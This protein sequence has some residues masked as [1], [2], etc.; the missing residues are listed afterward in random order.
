MPSRSRKTHSNGMSDGA[1]TVCDLPLILRVTMG[2]LRNVS[3]TIGVRRVSRDAFES[4]STRREAPVVLLRVDVRQR[5]DLDADRI[6]LVPPNDLAGADVSRE[7]RE[8]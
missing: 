2:H 1:S 3:G 4:R 8:L 6:A 5:L 7:R